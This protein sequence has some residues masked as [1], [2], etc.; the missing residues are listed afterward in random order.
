MTDS[1]TKPPNTGRRSGSPGQ[2]DGTTARAQSS[3]IAVV[4]LVGLTIAGAAA[5]ML[6]GATALDTGQQQAD[7]ESAE[8]SLAQVNVKASRVSLGTNNTEQITVG[9]GDAGTTRV[10]PDAGDI[11][12]TLVNQTTGAT[13]DVLL[14]DSLGRITYELDGERIAFE[15]GGVWRKSGNGSRML[16]RPDIHYRND[17]ADQPTVTIPL[18]IVEGEA[19]RGNDLTLSDAGTDLRYP[20]RG[21]DN[22]TNPV[23]SNT[24]I[25]L[26]VQSEYYLAWGDYFA[27]LT[28]GEPA[29]DHT[30]QTVSIA[31]IT[32]TE[33]KAVS[34]ALFQTG[35]DSDLEFGSG[36][37]ADSY[38]SSNGSYAETT[39]GSGTLT[40]AGSVEIDGKSTIRGDLVA[41]RSIEID[42]ASTTIHGNISYGNLDD[43]EIH[44]NADIKGW[45]ASNASVRSAPSIEG[46]V[47]NTFS[48]LNNSSTNVNDN[49]KEENISVEEDEASVE[50]GDDDV[51]TLHGAAGG[52]EYYV[53]D[54][55]ELEGEKLILDTTDGEIRL[56]VNED[57]E[58]EENANITVRGD[59]TARIYLREDFDMEAATVHIPEDRSTRLWVYG[60][61]DSEIE[62]EGGNTRFTGVLYIPDGDGVAIESN[63]EVFGGVVGGGDAEIESN[64]ELHFDEALTNVKPVPKGTAVPYITHLHLSVN[65]VDVEAD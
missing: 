65:Y 1:N 38:N 45:N 29:Y 7:L 46:Y 9:D 32:P 58:M 3:V 31:L 37:F 17:A 20:V 53:N 25:N 51:A 28:G 13:E 12:V 14:N 24:R 34:G 10:D 8:N 47:I 55:L 11:N 64:A 21:V 35:P 30:N 39:G 61:A 56:A 40:T 50:F 26:T 57:I 54:D 2:T 62:F 59:N 4:L 49:D 43:T 23:T 63:A 16:S 48:G 36:A 18:T 44:K 22:R 15:G 52:R 41:G 33:R 60:M 5:V 27:D 42:Q 6:V 19:A